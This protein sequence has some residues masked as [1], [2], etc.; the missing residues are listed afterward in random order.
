ML[1][2][3]SINGVAKT[4][5]INAPIKGIELKPKILSEV[6]AKNVKALKIKPRVTLGWKCEFL[7]RI[8]KYSQVPIKTKIK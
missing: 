1:L 3:N 8:L 7:E 2:Y 6:S 5:K 4:E